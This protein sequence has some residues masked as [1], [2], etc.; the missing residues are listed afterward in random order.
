MADMLSERR[1]PARQIKRDED[2]QNS[3]P[4]MNMNVFV[5]ETP[6]QL[7]N[8]LE[9]RYHLAL[10]DSVLIVILL[11]IF[12]QESYTS[13]TRPGDWAAVHY[14][15][16]EVASTGGVQRKLKFHS[17]ARIRGYFATYE[18]FILRRRLDAIARS[19]G[20]VNAVFLGNYWIDYMRHFAN[21]IDHERL[22]LLDDGTSTLLINDRR[23]EGRHLNNYSSWQRARLRLVDSL[24]GL[25]P[26]QIESVTFFTIYDLVTRKE[27]HVVRHN[28][29]YL[30]S[31]AG[32]V[33]PSE[34]VLFL[35]QTLEEEGLSRERYFYYL[36][37]MLVYFRGERI[38]YVPHK[39]EPPEKIAYIRD[40]L[41]LQVTRFNVPIEFQ[42]TMLRTRPKLLASF[43]SSALENC[44]IIFG[45][46]MKIKVFH[47]DPEECL[48]NI[49]FI[50]NL[51]TYYE[52]KSSS[53][54]EVVRL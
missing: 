24:I 27:D 47:I 9:A 25:K 42:L 53:A 14:V 22:F 13:I 26:K 43:C 17:S 54:F 23:R 40:E 48:R 41:G 36:R 32:A 3:V 38:V 15:P 50:R 29:S 46:E 16:S 44:R 52:S 6:H 37:K 4:D 19:L 30:R 12:S 21:V 18:L 8:A 31:V 39:G 45:N 20:K 33:P 35:G 34:E 2:Q 1:S 28:Y 11:K 5:I 51:Y 10:P 7:L 49:D